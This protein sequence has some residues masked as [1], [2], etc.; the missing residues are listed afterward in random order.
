VVA[1]IPDG[2]DFGMGRRIHVDRHPVRTPSDDL[3]IPD[4]DR[5]ERATSVLDILHREPD[6][7]AHK[8]DMLI[9]MIHTHLFDPKL[10]FGMEEA[11]SLGP[12]GILLRKRRVPVK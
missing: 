12:D 4:N 2:I 6:G 3:P 5:S 10:T 11:E 8:G 9:R 7:L 1:G